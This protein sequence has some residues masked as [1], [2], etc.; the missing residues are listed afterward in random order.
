MDVQRGRYGNHLYIKDDEGQYHCFFKGCGQRYKANFSRHVEGHEKKG[1]VV[2]EE[3][4]NALLSKYKDHPEMSHPR[5]KFRISKRSKDLPMEFCKKALDSLKKHPNVGHFLAPVDPI[6][7]GAVNYLQVIALPMDLGTV[8]AKLSATGEPGE[9]SSGYKSAEEF[10]TDVRL[11]WS[12]AKQY[13][14][15]GSSMWEI[16][17]ELSMIFESKLEK[18]KIS[19]EY[20]H[21]DKRLANRFPTTDISVS[22]MV[23]IF[24]TIQRHDVRTEP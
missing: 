9:K 21:T 12:N 18:Y 14:G 2:D 6:A 8:E 23:D 22:Q 19:T 20:S 24:D 16:A 13:N 7:S 17:N 5:Q 10:A 4:S 15:E 11:V 3:L 1:D